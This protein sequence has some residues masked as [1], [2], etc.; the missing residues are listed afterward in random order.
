[1]TLFKIHIAGRP[2]I[3]IGHEAPVVSVGRASTN[4]IT[5]IDD[6]LSRLHARITIREGTASVEDLGSMNGT[7]VNGVRITGRQPLK[8][9]DVIR[10]GNVEATLSQDQSSKVVIEYKDSPDLPRSTIVMS[11]EML[12]S[13][14]L[15][16]ATPGTDRWP[17]AMS[18]LQGLT[19]GL[20]RDVSAQQLLEDLVEKLFDFLEAE[21][22]VVLLKDASGEVEPVVV[23]TRKGRASKEDIRLSHTLVEAALERREAILLREGGGDAALASRSLIISGVTTAIVTPLEAGGEVIGLLYFDA[24]LTRKPFDEDDLRLVTVLAHVAAAKIQN[25]KLAEEVQ[26]KRVLEQEMAI[27]RTIQQRLLPHKTPHEGAFQLFATLRSAKE[28]GGD[29]FDYFWDEKRLFFCIGDVSGKGVPA[30]LVMALTKTLFRANAAFLDD[31]AQMMAAVNVRLYE[32]TDPTM[33]VTAFCGFLDL[34]SGRLVYSNAGH[35]RPLI[36]RP[37]S[38]LRTLEAKPGLALGVF[39]KFS[40]PLQEELL[41]PG[42]SLILYTD[43]VTEAVDPATQLFGLARLEAA[44]DAL[45]PSDPEG[46]V[47]ALIEAVDGFAKDA[48]QA[49]DITTLCI[50]YLGDKASLNSDGKGITVSTGTFAREA[51]SLGGVIALADEFITR[52]KLG[53]TPRYLLEFVLEELFTNMVKYNPDGGGRISVELAIQG[54]ELMILLSDPDCPRFDIRSD[55]PEVDPMQTL[56]PR[57][58]GGLG[59]H[60]VKKMVDRIE[61]DHLDRVGTIRLFKRLE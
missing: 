50:R 2:P 57:T 8:V 56:D 42:D 4:D 51:A 19:L 37:G 45:A 28:V 43:G 59:I 41:A 35:D 13:G 33:F 3:G 14:L 23:R 11:A 29:L 36:L 38:P 6:S 32:E 27:A 12:R 46:I 15:G 16:P 5:I 40:Y 17:R 44:M 24:F 9:G 1:M 25:A 47:R 10:F 60:L 18:V 54:P 52:N 48:P 61:Y 7:Q 20:I 39:P 21:H 31:P 26:K 53:E 34:E 55:A 49:D 30:A 22:G 58:P